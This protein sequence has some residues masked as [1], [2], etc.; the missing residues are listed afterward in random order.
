[1]KKYIPQEF[2]SVYDSTGKKIADCGWERDAAW[3]AERRKGTYRKS[4][5]ELPGP[6]V[7]V[8]PPKQLPT[9]EVVMSKEVEYEHIND[10]PH[11][12]WWLRPEHRDEVLPQLQESNLE[13]LDLK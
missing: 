13:P 7:D 2:W 6:V 11:D 10:D 9:N 8:T 4:N 3:L 12:G 1:M 5:H